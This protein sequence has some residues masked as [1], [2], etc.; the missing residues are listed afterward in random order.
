LGHRQMVGTRAITAHG[1]TS[2]TSEHIEHERFTA[3]KQSTYTT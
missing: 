3:T 2:V 1:T